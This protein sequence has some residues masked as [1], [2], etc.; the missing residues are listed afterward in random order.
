MAVVV[1]QLPQVFINTGAGK[2]F[3]IVSGRNVFFYSKIWLV[4]TLSGGFNRTN[5]YIYILFLHLHWKKTM[6]HTEREL[7]NGLYKH[8]D[9]ALETEIYADRE[10]GIQEAISYQ[11]HPILK[12]FYW[13]LITQRSILWKD[14]LIDGQTDRQRDR[15]IER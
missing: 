8:S 6:K 5:T 4:S 1:L 13:A 12:Y 2:Q 15:E 7:W 3:L 10:K 14:R 9:D 11:I